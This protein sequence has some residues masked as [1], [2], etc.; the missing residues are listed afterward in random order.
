MRA[1]SVD[2]TPGFHEVQWDGTDDVGQPQST[3][4]YLTRFA[5]GEE[6]QTRKMTMVK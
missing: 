1:F 4:V 3:G 6:V 5:Y 2:R